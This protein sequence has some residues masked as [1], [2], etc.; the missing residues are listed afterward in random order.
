MLS[1]DLCMDIQFRLLFI[2]FC[3]WICRHLLLPCLY[4][5]PI[6]WVFHQFP[7]KFIEK[8]WYGALRTFFYF[9]F[10]LFIYF[11]HSCLWFGH[12][13]SALLHKLKNSKA[14]VDVLKKQT[15]GSKEKVAKQQ[16]AIMKQFSRIGSWVMFILLFYQLLWFMTR[17]LPSVMSSRNGCGTF[18]I[19]NG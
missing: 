14:T 15:N 4:Y 5:N 12:H 2:W 17:D 1:S 16:Q 18:N 3:V 8:S 7:F 13:L 10:Y 11:M 9:Y 19:G 6:L